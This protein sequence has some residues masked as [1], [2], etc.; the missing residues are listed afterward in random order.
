M[1]DGGELD[2][3]RPGPNDQPHIRSTQHSP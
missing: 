2:G 3:F 1:G